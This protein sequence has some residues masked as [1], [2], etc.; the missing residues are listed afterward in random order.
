MPDLW[1]IYGMDSMIS[2]EFPIAYAF[3]YIFALLA[4]AYEGYCVLARG[5]RKI[6]TGDLYVQSFYVE[7]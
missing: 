2:M 5:Q 4:M 6:S 1:D 7:Y 3:L